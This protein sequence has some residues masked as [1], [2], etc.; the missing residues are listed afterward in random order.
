MTTAIGGYAQKEMNVLD[1]LFCLQGG[2]WVEY[3]PPML[4]S[5]YNTAAVTAHSHLIVA[6]GEKGISYHLNTVEVMDTREL[7]W[8][9]VTS[10]PLPYTEASGTICGDHLYL[11]GGYDDKDRTKTVLACSVTD[12]LF[13][14]KTS[15]LVWHKVADAPAYLSTCA[16][17]NGELLAVGGYNEEVATN[18][19]H[20]Y[21]PSVSDWDLIG[22]MPTA[23]CDCLV[24][25]LSTNEMLVVGG[26]IDAVTIAD[27]AHV[28]TFK[29]AVTEI[30][31]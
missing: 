11:L 26:T 19:I 17:V 4:T 3:F 5:R 24:A 28:V 18:A 25:V 1:K 21:D 23:K 31:K 7:V 22:N 16:A 8:S 12:L 20:M 29:L 9:T 10:L 13:S 6:G 27:E 30:E 2:Q 15:Q 14:P